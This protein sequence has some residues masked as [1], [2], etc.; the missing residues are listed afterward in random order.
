MN[1]TITT[2]Q[3]TAM[4]DWIKAIAAYHRGEM[5]MIAVESALDEKR[6]QYINT[7]VVSTGKATEFRDYNPARFTEAARAEARV[8]NRIH[9]YIT[10]RNGDRIV[11]KVFDF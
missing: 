2:E 1:T 4:T 7:I 5:R 9:V 8:S 11:D 10:R 3:A 6:R